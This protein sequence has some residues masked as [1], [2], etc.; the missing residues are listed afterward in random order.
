M[1]SIRQED[2]LGAGG[3]RGGGAGA[4]LRIGPFRLRLRAISSYVIAV[5]ISVERRD[6][7]RSLSGMAEE[8]VHVIARLPGR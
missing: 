7:T 6:V 8:S 2:A 3:G 1:V 5:F 4:L